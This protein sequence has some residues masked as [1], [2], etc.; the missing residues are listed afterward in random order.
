MTG[1]PAAWVRMIDPEVSRL[2]RERIGP[3]MEERRRLVPRRI[4]VI[5]NDMAT[6][7]LGQSSIRTQVIQEA[8]EQEVAARIALSWTELKNILAAVGVSFTEELAGDLKGQV[9]Q[10]IAVADLVQ[11]VNGAAGDD[12]RF[13]SSVERE[14][15]MLSSDVDLYCANLKR[16]AEQQGRTGQPILNFHG[17]VGAVQTGPYAAASVVQQFGVEQRQALA[18]ALDELR[19]RIET[20][21]ASALPQKS[22]V[23]ELIEEARQEVAKDRPNG[24]RL[25]SVL[26]GVATAVQTIGATEAAY[27]AVKLAAAMAG[28]P[29][30]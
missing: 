25:T 6:R 23:V 15:R 24:L 20:L 4:L 22:E 16:V 11:I 5:E 8:C 10:H 7:G 18:R 12:H 28:I 14:L 9:A 17:P 19:A 30:P 29:L 26:S 3:R 27:Q 13:H 21:E 1:M 2:V